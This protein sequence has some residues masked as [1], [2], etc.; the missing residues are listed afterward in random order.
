MNTYLKWKVNTQNSTQKLSP[1]NDVL[2]RFILQY[3]CHTLN[4]KNTAISFACS[5]GKI[6]FPL[7]SA[8][9]KTR[10]WKAPEIAHFRLQAFR[11]K[12]GLYPTLPIL[13]TFGRLGTQV[14]Q[15]MDIMSLPDIIRCLFKWGWGSESGIVTGEKIFFAD[16]H[17]GLHKQIDNV[18]KNFL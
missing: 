8:R 18:W 2:F 10:Q 12:S 9:I 17:P 5:F 1:F 7:S 13:A 6:P 16:T 15:R 14:F 3:T 4:H 11:K